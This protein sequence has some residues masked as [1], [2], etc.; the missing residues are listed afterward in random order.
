MLLRNGTCY[1]VEKS[2]RPPA[3]PALD[4]DEKCEVLIIGAGISGALLA[5]ELS[6][7]GVNVILVDKRLGG[8]GS[9]AASTGLLQYEADTPLSIL[10]RMVPADHAVRSYWLGLDAIGV[11]ED[12]AQQLGENSF[13]R[14]NCLYTASSASHVQPLKHEYN[15]RRDAGFR[16]HFL[17]PDEIQ[18]RFLVNAPAAILSE[19]DGQ[20]DTF[21]FT[22]KLLQFLAARGVRIYDDT[23]IAFADC[24]AANPVATTD[25]G[26][27]VQARRIAFAAGYES[28]EYL[29]TPVGSLRS[30][31]VTASTPMPNFKFWEGRALIWE[32]ARPYLYIRI[33][34]DNR[35][36]VGGEDEKDHRLHTS[37][38]ILKAK[39]GALAS[40]AA[41]L[42]P[43]LNFESEFTWGGVFGETKD[44]LPYFGAPPDMPGA[45]FILGYGGNGIT[46]SV[47]A[48]RILANLF[49]GRRDRD[50]EIFRFE[51]P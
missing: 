21:A 10:M 31:F 11:L 12:L 44:G 41:L 4:R 24:T 9:T 19:G 33:S 40:K 42:I 16:V 38:A 32:S 17:E 8:Y 39:E 7:N 3:Y 49:L 5:W 23:E 13:E 6:K 14:R 43:E 15:I 1:W 45:Y 25:Q 2:D 29:R 51:R 26:Y 34:R 22:Q 37:E 50:A 35:I 36:I 18:R 46:Y 28:L 20:L 48:A 27:A 47:I 30:T